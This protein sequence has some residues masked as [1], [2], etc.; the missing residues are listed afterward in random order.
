M[1]AEPDGLRFHGAMPTASG[2]DILSTSF[3]YFDSLMIQPS[4]VYHRIAADQKSHPKS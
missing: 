1:D 3:S 4:Q 2:N